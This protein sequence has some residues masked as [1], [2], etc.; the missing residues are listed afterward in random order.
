MTLMRNAKDEIVDLSTELT[1]AEF[2]EANKDRAAV[3]KRTFYA[4]VQKGIEDGS[5]TSFEDVLTRGKSTP[6]VAPVKDVNDIN[7]EAKENFFDTFMTNDESDEMEFGSQKI[8]AP[9][10]A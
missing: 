3:V 8:K 7:N 1:R 9:V 4:R 2:W 5:F 10:G 6:S